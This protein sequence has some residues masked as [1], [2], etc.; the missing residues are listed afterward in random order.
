CGTINKWIKT[1]AEDVGLD[2]GEP[3]QRQT[4]ATCCNVPYGGGH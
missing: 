4:V 1:L 3:P 2:A